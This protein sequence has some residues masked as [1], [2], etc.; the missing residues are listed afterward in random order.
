MT[1]SMTI[2]GLLFLSLVWACAAE[3]L[4]PVFESNDPNIHFL[5]LSPNELKF[6]KVRQGQ[7]LV[8][9]SVIVMPALGE[10]G[11]LTIEFQRSD[12]EEGFIRGL[13]FGEDTN[14]ENVH[15]FAGNGIE[16]LLT[17]QRLILRV[18]SGVV[19]HL[20]ND[21]KYFP[22][23][24]TFIDENVVG[25]VT[26]VAGDVS[27]SSDRESIRKKLFDVFVQYRGPASDRVP[28]TTVRR[29]PDGSYEGTFPS[30]V[31]VIPSRYPPRV[32]D[33]P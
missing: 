19:L 32:L 33:S 28:G 6:H 4:D 3:S 24:K 15:P 8:L 16:A 30:D 20:R 11:S 17:N 7:S 14:I 1:K 18:H 10:E 25:Q 31:P 27:Y 22:N 13:F 12:V 23:F 26:G 29:L 2:Q 5:P 9:N 21:M